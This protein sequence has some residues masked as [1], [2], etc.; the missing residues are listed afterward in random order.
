MAR[1]RSKPGFPAH[2]KVKKEVPV[3]MHI[4][5]KEL[6]KMIREAVK[7]GSR[8]RSKAKPGGKP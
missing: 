2:I 1:K 8:K 3:V 4:S 7:S 5:K 6:Q